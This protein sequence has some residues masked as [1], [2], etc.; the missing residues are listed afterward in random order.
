MPQEATASVSTPPH[1]KVLEEI[2]REAMPGLVEV[3]EKEG[4]EAVRYAL[5]DLR[6][7]HRDY[8]P[9]AW[10]RRADTEQKRKGWE[11]AVRIEKI[12]VRVLQEAQDRQVEEMAEVLSEGPKGLYEGTPEEP[13]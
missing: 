7:W 2:E 1:L 5:W 6:N 8:S 11:M 9:A 3:L 10:R 13:F 4:V 12:L